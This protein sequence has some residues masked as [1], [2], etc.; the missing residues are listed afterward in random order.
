VRGTAAAGF[1]LLVV[2]EE[3][4]ESVEGDLLERLQVEWE[5]QV[6]VAQGEASQH[7]SGHL[8]YAFVPAD[9]QVSAAARGS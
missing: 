6:V 7:V 8:E 4:S 2:P 9:A 5:V 3:A 1:D